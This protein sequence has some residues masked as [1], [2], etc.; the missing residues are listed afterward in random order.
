MSVPGHSVSEIWLHVY[1]L[2]MMGSVFLLPCSSRALHLSPMQRESK[3]GIK[4]NQAKMKNLNASA[5]YFQAHF[6]N[7]K[8][9]T[10]GLG[11]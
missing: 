5:K 1:M 9:E 11:A 10:D 6:T 3:V 2:L 8:I 4:Q 7:K